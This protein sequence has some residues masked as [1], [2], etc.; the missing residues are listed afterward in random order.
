[1]L[2]QTIQLETRYK[3]SQ[4]CKLKIKNCS[5]RLIFSSKTLSFSIPFTSQFF[6]TTQSPHLQTTCKQIPAF[7]P[8]NTYGTSSYLGIYLHR[9]LTQKKSNPRQRHQLFVAQCPN[10][11]VRRLC[12]IG[13]RNVI[14]SVPKREVHNIFNTANPLR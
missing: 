6:R 12:F 5:F 10:L 8:L 7:P 13:T 3:H 4:V 11:K 2:I 9:L 1:M 14:P